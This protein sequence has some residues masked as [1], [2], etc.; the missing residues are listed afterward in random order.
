MRIVPVKPTSINKAFKGRKFKTKD[1]LTFEKDSL[2][3]IKKHAL[4]DK[5]IGLKLEYGFSNSAQDVDS[6]IKLSQDILQ[7]KLNF[8]DKIIMQ[9]IVDKKVVKKGQEYW[10]YEFYTIIQ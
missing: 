2:Y 9:L 7:K 3:F 6:C 8:D 4:P 1:Y 5:P 10:A